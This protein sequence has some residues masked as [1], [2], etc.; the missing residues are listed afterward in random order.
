GAVKGIDAATTTFRDTY[1][2]MPGDMLN[3]GARLA[4]CTG[5][6][7]VAAGANVG[8]TRIDGNVE[9]TPQ[10]NAEMIAM[11]QQLSAA[12]LIAGI[13]PAQ[14]NAFGGF[15]PSAPIGGGFHAAFDNTGTLGSNAS[16]RAG[17][18]LILTAQ[19]GA[20]PAGTALTALQA[21]R[22]DRKL[23]DGVSNTGTVFDDAGCVS[24]TAGVYDEA[25]GN[26][27]CDL[28]VRFQN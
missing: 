26:A 25:N 9:A 11:W 14:Q 5:S 12:D 7:I 21:A 17:H 13:D 19:A 15:W 10:G 28:F 4:N 20:A 18:Y 24:A 23:D 22:I 3:A 27:N 16:S 6:C 2:A 1:A 8:N